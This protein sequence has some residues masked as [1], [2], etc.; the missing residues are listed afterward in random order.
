MAMMWQASAS[1]AHTKSLRPGLRGVAGK[2]P[3][4]VLPGVCL[5]GDAR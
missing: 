3:L 4:L 2:P 1:R 5:R